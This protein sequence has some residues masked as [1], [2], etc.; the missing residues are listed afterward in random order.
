MHVYLRVRNGATV[1]AAEYGISPAIA[2]SSPTCIQA[3]TYSILNSR[4]H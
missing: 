2:T 1:T 3:V 4:G